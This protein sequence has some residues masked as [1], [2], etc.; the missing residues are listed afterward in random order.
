MG[1]QRT[2]GV[3]VGA[4]VGA[5]VGEVVGAEVGAIV[6]ALVGAAVAPNLGTGFLAVIVNDLRRATRESYA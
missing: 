6:G 5:C 4:S 2:L 3:V 1:K